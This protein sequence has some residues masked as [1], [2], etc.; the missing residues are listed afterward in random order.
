MVFSPSAAKPRTDEDFR[1]RKN[2]EFHKKNFVDKRLPVEN[3]NINLAKDFPI[4]AMHV[5]DLGVMKRVLNCI[6]E[7]L[8]KEQR[9]VFS[10]QYASLASTLPSEFTGRRTRALKNLKDFKA[11][12]YRTFLLHTGQVVLKQFLSNEQYKHF[13]YFSVGIRILNS[14]NATAECINLADEYLKQ[15]VKKFSTFY[16]EN[17]R[18][19]NVHCLLHLAQHVKNFG[20][21]YK[22][23]AYKYENFNYQITQYAKKPSQILEQIANMVGRNWKHPDAKEKD[24]TGGFKISMRDRDAYFKLKDGTI[25]KVLAIN[26]NSVKGLRFHSA[27]PLF[28]EP[29]DSTVIGI[30]LLNITEGNPCEILASEIKFKYICLPYAERIVLTPLLDK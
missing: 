16:G 13:L 9:E 28:T 27:Q 18:V 10:E 2:K 29:L 4:D 6:V 15:F 25:L 24:C 23:S 30:V 7:Q 5:V 17:Q 8:P 14:N 11:V 26:N 12:E 19:H 1:L 3:L 20:P 22:F 21:L